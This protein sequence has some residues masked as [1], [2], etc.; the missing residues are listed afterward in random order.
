MKHIIRF[1]IALVFLMSVVAVPVYALDGDTSTKNAYTAEELA[2][3]RQ[4]M[5]ERLEEY[6]KKKAEAR[7]KAQDRIEE[8]KT[9]AKEHRLEVKKAVCE[10]LKARLQ[11]DT[12]RLGTNASKL[13][14]RFDSIY[15]RVQTFYDKKELNVENYEDLIATVDAAELEATTSVQALADS[16][17]DI[18][19]EDPNLAE[20]L[21]S[22]RL[23]ARDARKDLHDYREALVKLI[24][25]LRKA[26]V[27]A[28][29][30]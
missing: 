24:S 4:A 25:S 8:L 30:Q 14:A 19:C 16:K 3:K 9:E 27:A 6:K 1:S 7:E 21:E 5:L 10:R 2:A 20:Q 18:D 11:D 13:K 23:A 28:E 26:V 12:P 15:E 29:E 22:V 17:V